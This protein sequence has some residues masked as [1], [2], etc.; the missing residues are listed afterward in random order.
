LSDVELLP[1]IGLEP[2]PVLRAGSRRYVFH[3]SFK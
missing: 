2:I 3:L 1:T